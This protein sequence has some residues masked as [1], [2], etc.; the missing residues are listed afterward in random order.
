MS[1]FIQRFDELADARSPFCLGLDPSPD[2]LG[3]WGLA[4]D[5][6]GARAMCETVL[7]AVADEVAMVKPQSAYFERFGAA[8]IE[9][10]ESVIGELRR[11][12]VLVLLD[13]KRGD[14][15]STT[16]A[17][18]AAMLGPESALGADAVTASA[19]LGFGS[20][21][22][23]FD[24]AAADNGAVF[25][26]VASSNPEGR[27]LQGARLADGR[28]VA[29]SLADSI[30]TYNRDHGQAK[31]VGAVIGATRDDLDSGFFQRL[32]GALVLA[33]GIGAQGASY[34]A[35][36]AAFMG[37]RRRLI[38]PVSRAVLAAGPREADLRREITHHRELARRVRD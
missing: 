25:V 5:A 7:G 14:I 15:G 1:G 37:I 8:G 36:P 13:A 33:P 9:I 22:P 27:E 10:L 35:L 31:P 29:E 28:N 2:L 12:G 6:G 4:D 30:A 18:A 23:L 24:R 17:Y 19:Y 16:E 20:L 3:A 38:L 11:R 26:V 21:A 34:D 32:D